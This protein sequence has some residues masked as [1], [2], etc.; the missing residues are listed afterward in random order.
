MP[1][2]D[3]GSL[4]GAESSVLDAFRTRMH[5]HSLPLHPPSGPTAIENGADLQSIVCKAPIKD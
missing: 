1:G 4:L 2:A 3:V 5:F